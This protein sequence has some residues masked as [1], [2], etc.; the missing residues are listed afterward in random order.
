[1]TESRQV[2]RARAG[3]NNYW[4]PGRYGLM[5]P[6]ED[7]K[8]RKP[9]ATNRDRVSV[10]AI[11]RKQPRKR[12]SARPEPRHPAGMRHAWQR[13]AAFFAALRKATGQ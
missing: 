5:V 4:K 7:R 1:M 11:A 6:R 9:S 13:K 12:L 2:I 8:C 10:K 3:A